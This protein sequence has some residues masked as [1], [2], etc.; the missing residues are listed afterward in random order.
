MELI[1]ILM[2]IFI[3]LDIAAL[4]WG[5]DTRDTARNRRSNRSILFPEH[6]Y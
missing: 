4:R 3:V 2:L 1:I 6:H 5:K